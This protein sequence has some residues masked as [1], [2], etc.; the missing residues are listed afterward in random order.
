MN[1]KM[2]IF[3]F[4]VVLV[5]SNLWGA[6]FLQAQQPVFTESFDDP[7][8]PGWEHLPNAVVVDGVLRIEPGLINPNNRN[9]LEC[10]LSEAAF[11]TGLERNANVVVMSCYAPLFGHIDAWQ[12]VPNL[13]WFDNLSAYG[14]PSY[15]IQQMFSCNRGDIVLP[16]NLQTPAPYTQRLYAS[17]VRDNKTGEI[18][19]KVVNSLKDPVEAHIN[20]SGD[21]ATSSAKAIVLT[22]PKLMDE[23]SFEVPR[24]IF[25]VEEKVQN[26]S[27]SFSY[28]FRPYSFTVL[29]LLTESTPT[30]ETTKIRRTER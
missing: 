3:W 8:L 15:Y 29:R 27:S 4:A 21:R 11:M 1:M 9:N 22:S 10:A 18:I 20:L 13:I 6:V 19:L 17:A 26:A 16:V 25:P 14:T 30:G 23:N 2:H 5:V 7:A 28:S 12:W 24:N